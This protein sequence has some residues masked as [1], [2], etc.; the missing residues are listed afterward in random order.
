MAKRSGV[1]LPREAVL[2]DER[3]AYVFEQVV[4]KSVRGKVG[5]ARHDVKLLQR[6]GEGWLVSGVDN[7]DD[8]VFQGAG[9]LWSL[10]GAGAQAA[11]DDD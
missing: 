4:D 8:V 9:V 10:Q 6:Q 11:D 1:L 3:G 2:Y 7:D 5:Y